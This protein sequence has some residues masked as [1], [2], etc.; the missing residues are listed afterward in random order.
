MAELPNFSFANGLVKALFEGI[1]VLGMDSLSRHLVGNRPVPRIEAVDTK[2]PC[3][4]I[5]VIMVRNAPRPAAGTAQSFS[6]RQGS[7]AVTQIPKRLAYPGEQ[8]SD[9]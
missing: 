1:E 4:P 6:S 5:G 7:L 9:D 8:A 3:R 2:M